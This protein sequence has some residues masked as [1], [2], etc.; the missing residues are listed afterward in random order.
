IWDVATRRRRCTLDGFGY[1]AF[2]PDGHTVAIGCRDTVTLWDADTGGQLTSWSTDAHGIQ[3]IAY[4]RDGKYLAVVGDYTP[5]EVWDV[6]RQTLCQTL[7]SPVEHVAA[8][9][10]SADGRLLAS[11]GED[12]TIRLWDLATGLA[13]GILTGHHDKVSS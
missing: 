11:A 4:S 7:T 5:I 3:R 2:A 9:A 8:V 12:Q 6:E 13:S 10:F 1:L